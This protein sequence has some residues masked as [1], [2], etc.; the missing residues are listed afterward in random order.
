MGWRILLVDDDSLLR[1]T[2]AET[3]SAEGHAVHE[4]E[5]GGQALELHVLRRR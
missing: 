3:F 2:L 5:H 4:A 1:E